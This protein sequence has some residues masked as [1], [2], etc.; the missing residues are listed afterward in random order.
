MKATDL[1]DILTYA[2]H[3]RDRLFVIHIDSLLLENAENLFTDFAVLRSLNIRLILVFGISARLQRLAQAQGKTIGDTDGIGVTDEATLTLARLAAGEEGQEILRLLANYNLKGSLNNAVWAHPAGIIQGVNHQF[4]GKV[5]KV[6]AH[7]LETLLNQHIIPVISPIVFDGDGRTY[8]V[9]ADQA[10]ARVAQVMKASKLIY[11]TAGLSAPDARE[12]TEQEAEVFLEKNKATLHPALRRKID[13]SIQAC[14]GRVHRCHILDGQND[15]ALFNELFSK[16]G[17]GTMIYTNE[18][19]AIRCATQKDVTE[20]LNLIENSVASQELARWSRQDILDC[21]SDF[22]VFEIDGSIVGCVTLKMLH[23][24]PKVAE[25]G[26]L[27]VSGRYENRGIGSRLIQYA[28]KRAHELGVQ[29]LLA[30]STQAFHYLEK[31]GG[32]QEGGIEILPENRLK[33][34]EA[35]KRNSKI[36]YKDLV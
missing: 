18:Y 3:F 4:T 30:L 5:E 15:E 27:F 20:I 33:K 32:F 21:L 13:C 9:N 10:A 31:K 28:E 35:S 29:R 23:Q 11:M 24:Q 19:K 7:F 2:S 36:L 6:D 16:S 34:Y 17:I 1:R 8:C 12:L 25:M 22:Y 14:K 26:C